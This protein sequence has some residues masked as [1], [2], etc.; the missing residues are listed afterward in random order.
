MRMT[1]FFFRR[2]T[3]NRRTDAARELKVHAR[4]AINADDDTVVTISERDCGDPG[5]GGARTIVLVMHP[6]RPTEAVK[7]NKPLEQVTQSDI[8]DAL[9]PLVAQTALS[10][11]PPKPK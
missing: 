9:A 8:S 6:R 2:K 10:E 4:T 1:P 11:L 3:S 5:C 7:I